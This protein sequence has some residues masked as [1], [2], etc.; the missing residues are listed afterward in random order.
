MH[1]L[2]I[3]LLLVIKTSSE[4]NRNKILEKINKVKSWFFEKI[5]IIDKFLAILIKKKREYIN[6]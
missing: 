3:R 1:I 4:I 6:Y 5:N 2:I